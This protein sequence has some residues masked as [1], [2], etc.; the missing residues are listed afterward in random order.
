MSEWKLAMPAAE[1]WQE[2]TDALDKAQ[3][4]PE[5]KV[6]IKGDGVGMRWRFNKDVLEKVATVLGV[7]F[8]VEV[9]DVRNMMGAGGG[10]DG[11][12]L[13]YQ[14]LDSL[15]GAFGY[16]I[17]VNPL[18]SPEA[19]NLAT[20]H[21]IQH[22]F[23]LEEGRMK[24]FDLGYNTNLPLVGENAEKYMADPTEVDADQMALNLHKLE[25][26]S[27]TIPIS[28]LE[29]SE[30]P[31]FAD[32]LEEGW[33][34][35]EAVEEIDMMVKENEIGVDEWMA[36]RHL[37][38][39]VA[40]P[41]Y[42]NVWYHVTSID[43]LDSISKQGLTPR[44]EGGQSTN[45]PTHAVAENAV[46]LWPTISLA[47]AYFGALPFKQREVILRITNID[48]AKLAPD[49]EAFT[50]WLSQQFND[51]RNWPEEDDRTLYREILK[52]SPT[53]QQEVKVTEE[54]EDEYMNLSYEAGL[55]ILAEISPGLRKEIV[56]YFAQTDPT[57]PVMYYGTIP[58][59]D[60]AVASLLTFEQLEEEFNEKTDHPYIRA[61]EG[62]SPEEYQKLEEDYHE[63]LD[64]YLADIMEDKQIRQFINV[65]DIEE[66][67]QTAYEDE[68]DEYE[69]HFT[70]QPIQEYP[71][72]WT[73]DYGPTPTPWYQQT[74]VL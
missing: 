19:A 63:K 13:Q 4:H 65:E 51:N 12:R 30:G 3:P 66:M 46:Y 72:A 28:Q 70:Y 37:E 11:A 44:I 14:W 59:D 36:G 38:A 25:Q 17:H 26:Y 47:R 23:Q 74:P 43:N 9:A 54:D 6:V 52:S 55:Y 61:W 57:A 34:F 29:G 21:E 15:G 58:P 41:Y 67:I 45:W 31:Y 1:N 50:D 22:I 64:Q 39:K 24:P 48:Q 62:Y 35:Q 68:N 69:E 73:P 49:H 8:S 56:E 16:Q 27:T 18:L 40:M 33:P 7:T 20:W 53:L 32:L 71:K 2:L 5:G 42:N 60:I 10:M